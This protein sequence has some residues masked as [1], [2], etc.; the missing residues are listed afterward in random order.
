MHAPLWRK[1]RR[2]NDWLAAFT[3]EAATK[4]QASGLAKVFIAPANI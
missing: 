3:S 2:S 1:K 4:F